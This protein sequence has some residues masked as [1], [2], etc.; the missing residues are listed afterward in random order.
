[1]IQGCQV[2]FQG[3]GL[4]DG[5]SFAAA[6]AFTTA[7]ATGT[8]PTPALVLAAGTHC[9]CIRVHTARSV[10]CSVCSAEESRAADSYTIL[11][12]GADLKTGGSLTVTV[13]R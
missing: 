10:P 13:A 12:A 8:L 2:E 11:A 3:P 7:T 4:T 5:R 1:M 6:G 9:C